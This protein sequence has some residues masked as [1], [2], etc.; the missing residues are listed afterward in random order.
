MLRFSLIIAVLAGIA[1]LAVSQLKVADK[2]KTLTADLETTRQSLS[3]SQEAERKAKKEAKDATAAADTA[4]KDL[5]TTRND[6]AAA[7]EKADQQEKRANDRA[8]RLDRTTQ[9][10][11]DAQAKLAAWLDL[12]RSNDELK[13]KRVEN[14]KLVG[15]N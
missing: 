7:S 3:T 6:L 4:K 10:R 11:N 1:A 14:K 9:E 2:I 8:A 15:E 12:G 5:E 13:A